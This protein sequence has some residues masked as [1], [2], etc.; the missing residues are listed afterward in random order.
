[1]KYAL[2]ARIAKGGSVLR[3][4]VQAPAH[5]LPPGAAFSSRWELRAPLVSERCEARFVKLGG[6]LLARAEFGLMLFE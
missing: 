4:Y 2:T 6:F 1:M 3:E 5:L